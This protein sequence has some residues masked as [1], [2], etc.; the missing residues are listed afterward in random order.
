MSDDKKLDDKTIDETLAAEAKKVEEERAEQ[1]EAVEAEVVEEPKKKELPAELQKYKTENT[2]VMSPIIYQQMKLI[3]ND[4]VKSRAIPKGFEN[5][6]QVFVAMQ[7][8]REMGMKP[9]ESLQSLYMVNG[10]LSLWGKATIRRVREFGYQVEYLDETPEKVTAH[11]YKKVDGE[12][13]EDYKET[14][15]FA[16]AEKSGYTK[17]KDG[18]KFGWKEG[19]NRRLKLRYGAL[20]LIVR[21]SIPEVFGSAVGIVEVDEDVNM[22]SLPAPIDMTVHVE[23]LKTAK[24]EEELKRFWVALPAEAKDDELVTKTKDEIKEKLEEA[25]NDSK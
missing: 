5:A 11:V 7:A 20:S 22:K 2:D 19:T 18:L 8:G 1:T 12:I 9:Y 6:D 23:K 15:T 10:G 3:A 4:F 14:Y 16:E 24:T 21:T 25:Q 17:G 13:V